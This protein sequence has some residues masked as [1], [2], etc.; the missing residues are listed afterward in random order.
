MT[1]KR[2]Q[3]PYWEMT[4]KEL[5]EATGEFDE[6]FAAESFEPLSAADQARWEKVKRKSAQA[7]NGASTRLISVRLSRD[8]IAR[9]DALA[10]KMRITRQGLI[11]RGLKAVLAAEGEL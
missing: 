8:L 6:E 9:C 1:K 3:N 4:K 5:T 10:R 2:V 11:S 7:R